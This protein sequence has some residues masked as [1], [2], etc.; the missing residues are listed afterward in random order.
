MIEKTH[1]RHLAY[2]QAAPAAAAPQL[3]IRRRAVV[4]KFGWPINVAYVYV[5]FSD[6][7]PRVAIADMDCC[8]WLRLPSLIHFFPFVDGFDWN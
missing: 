5:D 1:T 3:V 7:F 6:W 4:A 2:Q 8:D